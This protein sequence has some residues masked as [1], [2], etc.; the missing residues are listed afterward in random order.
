LVKIETKIVRHGRSVTFQMA[1]R[2]S[3][4]QMGA[5]RHFILQYVARPWRRLVSRWPVRKPNA[6]FAWRR[7][8]TFWNLNLWGRMLVGDRAKLGLGGASG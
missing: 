3:S 1:V 5:G 6:A 2:S 4:D 7:Q 8:M